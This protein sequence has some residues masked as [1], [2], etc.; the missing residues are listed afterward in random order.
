MTVIIID[1]DISA[2][3]QKKRKSEQNISSWIRTSTGRGYT[4]PIAHTRESE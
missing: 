3:V 4:D 1:H 2:R